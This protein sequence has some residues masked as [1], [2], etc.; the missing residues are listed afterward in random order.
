MMEAKE[1]F[2]S[3]ASTRYEMDGFAKF[4]KDTKLSLKVPCIHVAGSNGKGAT[5]KFLRDIYLHAG[6]KVATFTSPWFYDYNEMIQINGSPISDDD[7]ERIFMSEKK[8]IT[9]YDLSPFEAQVYIA[10]TY[11]NEKKPDVVI[12][13]CGIGGALDATNIKGLTPILSIITTV[14]LEHTEFLGRSVSEIALSKGGIIKEYAPVLT[15]KLEES[16]QTTLRDLSHD[17][18]APY[19]E[20]EDFHFEVCDSVGWTFDY[21]PFKSLYIPCLAKYQISNAC[22]AIEA[23]KILQDEFKVSE[24]DIR[25]ALS[26]ET[27]ILHLEKHGNV[28][29]DGAH[30]PEAIKALMSDIYNWSKGK[31]VH[32]LFASF[33]D[34]NIANEFPILARDTSS[35]TLTTFD[36]PRAREE[37]DYFL[38]VDDFH[39]EEDYKKALKDLI[40]QYPDDLILVTGSLAFASIVRKY[41]MEELSL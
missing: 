21:R 24:E 15:G 9:K 11:F 20:V 8:K 28:I 39:F 14:S 26:E 29:F 31:N 40:E 36:N 34:K 32:V 17:L 10:Y 23:T 16:A 18:D 5:V 3:H 22:L 37:I 4:V 41:A 25:E 27:P 12:I 38:Y 35:I 33:R 13:E 7:L 6:Y 1:Y 30:N 19:H 2:R